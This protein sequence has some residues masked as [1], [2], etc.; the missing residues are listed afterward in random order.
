[1]DRSE[2]TY[3]EG[4]SEGL[5]SAVLDWEV[6]APY[7]VDNQGL[8]FQPSL[9]ILPF[10]YKGCYTCYFEL[11]LHRDVAAGKSPIIGFA[12]PG[13][14]RMGGCGAPSA[15][16]ITTHGQPYIYT[17]YGIVSKIP[18][19][20]FATGDVIGMGITKVHKKY[21]PDKFQIDTEPF[22]PPDEQMP[23][24]FVAFVTLNGKLV[25]T[26][27]SPIISFL[28]VPFV[29]YHTSG[30]VDS[31]NIS[32]SPSN[33]WV[34]DLR[35]H[36]DTMPV[37]PVK[38]FEWK[39]PNYYSKE[40]VAAD[41]YLERLPKEI[42]QELIIPFHMNGSS[43][44]HFMSRTHRTLDITDYDRRAYSYGSLKNFNQDLLPGYIPYDLPSKIG[45]DAATHIVNQFDL[46]KPS[47]DEIAVILK[48]YNLDADLPPK[49]EWPQ[50]WNDLMESLRNCIIMRLIYSLALTIGTSLSDPKFPKDL[51]VP[52]AFYQCTRMLLLL[53]SP[54]LAD[55]I[56]NI[57]PN[58]DPLIV[59]E[60]SYDSFRRFYATHIPVRWS[61][62]VDKPFWKWILPAVLLL[63]KLPH[64]NFDLTTPDLPDYI[65][66]VLR[67]PGP[68]NYHIRHFTVIA[69]THLPFSLVPHSSDLSV[70]NLFEQAL[71][72]I[73]EARKL[74]RS[75][76]ESEKANLLEYCK[77]LDTKMNSKKRGEV[78]EAETTAA[79]LLWIFGDVPEVNDVLGFELPAKSFSARIAGWISYLI[80]EP[81]ASELELL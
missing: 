24:A 33:P 31:V 77:E 65:D 17:G 64:W 36:I 57:E 74:I 15:I 44:W 2:S 50:N 8:F 67:N 58:K 53:I 12:H 41:D 75:R 39:I 29:N 11:T 61:K 47:R 30:G 73:Y 18:Q 38:D 14:R 7:S 63:R 54:D 45:I 1:M 10:P 32:G 20:S 5:Y 35:R 26:E 70:P 51:F 21:F 43:I 28:L 22:W 52:Q 60:T 27:P 9:P 78:E 34:Y 56:Q 55:I 59:L 68:K 16:F 80:W 76:Y 46:M 48:R 69:N 81:A 23:D 62:T 6:E 66:R 42:P 4:R 71:V 40:D 19:V 3:E 49:R 13:L 37:V 79:A 72:G 25:H